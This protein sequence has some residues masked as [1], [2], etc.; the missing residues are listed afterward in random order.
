MDAK[1]AAGKLVRAY[2]SKNNE[3]DDWLESWFSKRTQLRCTSVISEEEQVV[4]VEVEGT[5][6]PQFDQRPGLRLVSIRPH[7]FRGFKALRNQLI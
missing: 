3:G 1:G 4:P 6:A 5:Q 2:A 7:Y